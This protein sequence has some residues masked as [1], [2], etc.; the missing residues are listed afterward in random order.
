MANVYL[1]TMYN[2][3]LGVGGQDWTYKLLLTWGGTPIDGAASNEDDLGGNDFVFGVDWE[4]P[5]VAW[6]KTLHL[7]QVYLD[8]ITVSTVRRDSRLVPDDPENYDATEAVPFTV[9]VFGERLTGGSGHLGLEQTLFMRKKVSSGNQGR[10]NLRGVLL[11]GDVESGPQ[12]VTV[13]RSDSPVRPGGAVLA[14]SNAA[15][16]AG[17]L[18]GQEPGYA[19]LTLA[20][21][22]LDDENDNA[23]MNLRPVQMFISAGVK[24]KSLTNNNRMTGEEKARRKL[25]RAGYTVTLPPE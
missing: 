1:A 4:E 21:G 10:I 17:G 25:E 20:V 18:I 8:R 22:T 24:P 16:T 12:G 6:W 9:G 3:W 14:A 11:L 19:G 7:S 5:L 23:D 15:L 2:Y 13:L